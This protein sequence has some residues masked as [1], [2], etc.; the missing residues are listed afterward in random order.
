MVY[1]D[2]ID[3]F[4]TRLNALVSKGDSILSTKKKVVR[5]LHRMPLLRCK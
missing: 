5:S 2:N 1:N 4:N 3:N